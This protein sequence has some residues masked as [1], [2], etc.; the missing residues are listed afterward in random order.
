M[1]FIRKRNVVKKNNITKPDAWAFFHCIQAFLMYGSGLKLILI[2]SNRI[3]TFLVSQFNF[4]FAWCCS[5]INAI[6]LT[7]CVW[8]TEWTPFLVIRGRPYGCGLMYP[9]NRIRE[10]Q[11]ENSR[12][13]NSLNEWK[14]H[15]SITQCY[16]HQ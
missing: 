9:A 10:D 14:W 4:F 11:N 13:K 8:L 15:D 5:L 6:P 3:N 1:L 7:A 12:G 16:H 2:Q